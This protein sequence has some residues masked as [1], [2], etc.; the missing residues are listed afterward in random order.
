M[1]A[2]AAELLRRAAVGA[3]LGTYKTND[4]GEIF[5]IIFK[6]FVRAFEF[7]SKKDLDFHKCKKRNRQATVIQCNR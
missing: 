5:T 6:L 1:Q 7:Q 3:L 4:L 2:S